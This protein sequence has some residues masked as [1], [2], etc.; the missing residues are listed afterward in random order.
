VRL[1]NT[2]RHADALVDLLVDCGP[3]TAAECCAK[4][5]WTRGRFDSALRVARDEVCEDLGLTIPHPTPDDGWRYQVTT[6]WAP[7]EAGAAHAM[8]MVEAR[9]RSIHR[10]VRIV[11]PALDPRTK[12]GR[13]ANFLDKHLT[14]LLGT[15]KEINDG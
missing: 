2:A 11:K 13:R 15:L 9:L 5:G 10:D 14:H 12:A 8:G 3:L 6:E 4:L 1:E 7:V